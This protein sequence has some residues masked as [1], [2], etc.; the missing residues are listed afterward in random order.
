MRYKIRKYEIRTENAAKTISQPAKSVLEWIKQEASCDSILDYGCGKLRYAHHL[1]NECK[2]LGLIDSEIQIGRKQTINGDYTTVR[3]YAL[4]QWPHAR[5]IA[6]EDFWKGLHKRTYDLIFC[7]NV[8]SAIPSSKIRQ[9]TLDALHGALKKTGR[10]L[11]VNQYT[12]SY[13]QHQITSKKAVAYFDGYLLPSGR[14]AYYYGLL[15]TTKMSKM[16]KQSGFSI[17][18]TWN[19]SQSAF[20]IATKEQTNV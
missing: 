16:L 10:V 4:Q 15:S 20:V 1:A 3:K 14:K 8:F 6:L 19:R 11:V 5:V 7:A 17:I 9:R 18:K 2:Y 12:N 13:F